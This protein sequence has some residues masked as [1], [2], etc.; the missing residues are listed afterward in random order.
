MLPSSARAQDVVENAPDMP[1]NKAPA[2]SAAPMVLSVVCTALFI[3]AV[4]ALLAGLA[5]ACKSNRMSAATAC[6]FAGAFLVTCPA[7][8]IA[9]LFAGRYLTI[10]VMPHH[11]VA[12][13]PQDF[14]AADRVYLV[15]GCF[16]LAS[17]IAAPLG[18]LAIIAAFFFKKPQSTT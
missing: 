4:I 8:G 13:Q 7:F 3:A 5:I 17:F 15:T 18:L 14:A 6:F 9:A 16:M 11:D 1:E 2:R 12:P 10:V